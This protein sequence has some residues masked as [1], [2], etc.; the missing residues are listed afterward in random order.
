MTEKK[1]DGVKKK[2]NSKKKQNDSNN[3]NTLKTSQNS[4]QAQKDLENN[5]QE[6]QENNNNIQDNSNDIM[7]YIYKHIIDYDID[8]IRKRYNII[9]K[10][11]SIYLIR[12]FIKN[13]TS[14]WTDVQVVKEWT[15][16]ESRKIDPAISRLIQ[17]GL[18]ERTTKKHRKFLR[19][20]KKLLEELKIIADEKER[21][22]KLLEEDTDIE[23]KIN[24]VI[25][26]YYMDKLMK[27]VSGYPDIKSLEIDVKALDKVDITLSDWVMENPD[28]AINQFK[29]AI[30]KID[31]P[32]DI[33]KIEI[34]TRFKNLS[35]PAQKNIRDIKSESNAQLFELDVMVRKATDVKPKLVLAAFECRRCGNTMTVEQIEEI[36][37]EPFLCESCETRGPFKLLTK[38]SEF[39]NYQRLTVE[40]TR[41]RLRGIDRPKQIK[42]ILDDDLTEKGIMPGDRIR[43][44]AIPRIT[45][46]QRQNKKSLVFNVHLEANNIMKLESSFEDIK[47]TKADE[48]KIKKLAKNP[49]IYEM[50][51][52]SIA[53]HIKGYKDVKQGIMYQLFS[54]PPIEM[55]DGSRIRGDIH[56]LMLGD[57]ST[58]KSD[59]LDNITK[60]IAPRSIF[61]TGTG[62]SGVGLT[63]TAVKDE[64]SGEWVLEAGALVLANG[65]LAAIDEFSHM[66]KEDMA[67][68]HEAMEQQRISIAKAGIYAT[69]P[70][71]TSVL[72]ACNPKMGRFDDYTS[73]SSQI[74]IP[75]PLISRFDL[76]FFV[77]DDINDTIEVTE[78]ILNTAKD[79]KSVQPTIP[80]KTLRQYLAYTRRNIFPILTDK[81]SDKIR[82][83]YLRMRGADNEGAAISITPRQLWAVI[84][85]SSASARIRLSKKII[86]ED[87][88]RAIDILTMS[89]KDAGLDPDTGEVDIDKFMGGVAAS[90]RANI[91]KILNII[92]DIEK[93]FGTASKEEIVNGA[94]EE[95]MDEERLGE[96]MIMLKKRAEIYE[97]KPG[98]FKVVNK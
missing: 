97:P 36:I 18:L 44:T 24:D 66:S 83:F 19:P 27:I 40:E 88:E 92:R 49:E 71:E 73:L 31:L 42:V 84:R 76:I 58:G 14:D 12:A 79:P 69:F 78:Q 86:T 47:I 1:G 57:P 87:A 9:D 38:E 46:K 5:I 50:I 52:E 68:M 81:A 26:T 95:G 74:E 23:T 93:Q 35:Q 85:L 2:I 55:D 37:K 63:A 41:E 39:I 56:I 61:T 59:I 70:C 30:Y 21:V 72:A 65:G 16:L 89:L 4:K 94:K 28:E 62:S 7:I 6:I 29:K 11:G 75:P 3:L 60:N 8:T 64:E 34:H 91:V 22:Q 43:I 54:S 53:P 33:L 82:D 45:R 67:Y 10:K 15:N 17:V 13:K 77:R 20:T 96:L 32:T 25:R 80:Y 90:Q 98:Q 51:Q 48:K